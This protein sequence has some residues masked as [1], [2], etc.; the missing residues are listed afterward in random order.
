MT[1]RI[2]WSPGPFQPAD[3][4][5]S[6]IFHAAIARSPILLDLFVAHV[7]AQSVGTAD[8]CEAFFNSAVDLGHD[9]EHWYFAVQFAVCA[10][11]VLDGGRC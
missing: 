11:R 4:L 2:A 1:P 9:E 6:A 3:L 7:A 8:S 5:L 10:G